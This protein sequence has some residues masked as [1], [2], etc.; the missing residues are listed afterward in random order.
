MGLPDLEGRRQILGVHT[1]SMLAS[2]LLS[3]E[4]WTA[5]G[6]L[7]SMALETKDFSGAELAGLVRAA[8]S[9]ALARHLERSNS[10]PHSSLPIYSIYCASFL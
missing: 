4:E 7:E 2:G 5:G 8:S 1:R 3:L 10:R 9:H 6:T